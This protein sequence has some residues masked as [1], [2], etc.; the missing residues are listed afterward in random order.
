MYLTLDSCVSN[1]SE[2]PTYEAAS[3]IELRLQTATVGQELTA[4]VQ[5]RV[6]WISNLPVVLTGQLQSDGS[7]RY[8]GRY[9]SDIVSGE[10][11]DLDFQELTLRPDDNAGLSGTLQVVDTVQY[12]FGSFFTKTVRATVRSA[13]RQTFL[14]GNR[15]TNGTF[16]GFGTLQACQGICPGRLAGQ[17]VTI[18]LDVVQSGASLSGHFGTI[19]VTG[20]ANGASMTLSGELRGGLESNGVGV[21]LSRLESLVGTVDALGRL[22]GTIQLYNEGMYDT[23]PGAATV[24]APFTERLTIELT[25]VIRR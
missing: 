15:T 20:T 1:R 18:A 16:D 23:Q 19:P 7:I 13:S 5:S 6:S 21:T 3:L 10:F 9:Q 25:S 17:R 12:S 22:T 24:A 4:V 8:R 2:C 11:R 14:D